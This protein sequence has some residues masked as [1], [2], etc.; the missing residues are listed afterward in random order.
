MTIVA[1]A[2][3]LPFYRFFKSEEEHRH[4]LERCR[5]SA[6][7]LLESLRDGR[8]G[9]AVRREY[10]ERLRYYLSDLPKIAGVGN[11]ML[12]DD[13]VRV[14]YA[15][16]AQDADALPPPFA[17]ALSRVIANQFALND[18]YDVVR[19]HEQAVNAGNWTQPFPFEAA[20]AF[21]GVVDENTP[22][23]F[24]PE[25]GQGL[26]RVEQLAP[27]ASVA[28]EQQPASS[29]AIQPPPLPAGAPDAEHSRQRQMATAANALWRV[30]L[31]G[32]DLPVA[33]DGW[34]QAA[35]KLGEKI[36]PI[37]D[38]LRERV[39][40]VFGTHLPAMPRGEKIAILGQV[41]RR[42]AVGWR[43]TSNTAQAT[44]LPHLAIA[45]DAVIV[46]LGCEIIDDPSG[47]AEMRVTFNEGPTETRQTEELVGTA[48]HSVHSALVLLLG[49]PGVKMWLMTAGRWR[50]GVDLLLKTI[51]R[52]S[53]R[54]DLKLRGRVRRTQG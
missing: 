12:A 9:N 53:R 21:F 52:P 14:L 44:A 13:E 24:E 2:Q 51:E 23:I 54:L 38:F 26:H 22:R 40:K 33:I 29:S 18:F 4:S 28:P 50:F 19:R 48:M 6:E 15:M 27:S 37:L 35:H 25:V 42:L 10:A 17:A 1:G 46:S 8:Y 36:G 7:R 31:K 30:F 41:E 43:I 32:K 34:T 45:A 39:T 5:V 3:N 49:D 47:D 16:L 11:I 20:K